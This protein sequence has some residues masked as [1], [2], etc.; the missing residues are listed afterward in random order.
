MDIQMPVMDGLTATRL[1]RER[2]RGSGSHLPII[3]VTAG[4]TLEDRENCLTAG[5][6]GFVS[7][8]FRADDLLRTV[9]ELVV[10]KR[11]PAIVPPAA[12]EVE[13][14]PGPAGEEPCL[15][16][17]TALRNLDG[18]EAFLREL[19]EMFLDQYPAALAAIT[20]AVEREASEELKHSAHALKGSS[21]VVGARAAAAVALELEDLGRAGKAD[22]AG[23]V[24]ERL[25][26]RLAEL[27]SALA[28]ELE[29]S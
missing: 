20:G 1:I 18:D 28:A 9:D 10:E 12:S 19:S 15:D 7:K 21:R 24:L 4:A 27:G 17:S 3:A 23:E 2:E 29:R 8:P 14:E 13:S 5:M 11:A 16:W 25:R 26:N 6:D 22:E